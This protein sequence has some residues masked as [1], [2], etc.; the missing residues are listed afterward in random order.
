MTDHRVSIR[1]LLRVSVL[2][3]VTLGAAG[4]G[5]LAARMEFQQ[6]NRAYADG[7]Y[8]RAIDHY[9]KGLDKDPSMQQVWRSVGL[10][11]M[12]LIRPEDSLEEQGKRADQAIKAFKEYLK[13]DPND[14]K[15]SD[16]L[17]TTRINSKR[18]DEALT[19]LN[20][21]ARQHPND[22]R[23]PEAIARVLI[24][25]GRLQ[26]AYDAAS[27]PGVSPSASTFSTIAVQVWRKV[28]VDPK[29]PQV[30]LL[31]TEERT[32]WL[33]LGLKAIDRA[34]K[35][36]DKDLSTL[37]YYGLLLREK[38]KLETDPE[39]ILEIQLEA[40]KWTDKAI[41]LSKASQPPAGAAPAKPN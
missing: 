9:Q 11:H 34:A 38:A 4:C 24:E 10:A 40:Q 16:Y 3:L 30:N 17:L 29:K 12:A 18:Y 23:I 1:S 13:Y 35:L 8:S 37:A 32:R 26:E 28:F 33:E 7:E 19:Q 6:G 5:K 22:Q 27:K 20:E 14:T 21:E 2:G 31:S 25:A 39:K 41:A 36:D 15:I